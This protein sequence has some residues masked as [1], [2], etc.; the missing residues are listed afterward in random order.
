MQLIVVQGYSTLTAFGRVL[1]T[2]CIIKERVKAKLPVAYSENLDQSPGVPYQPVQFPKGLWSITEVMLTNHPLIAPVFIRTDAHQLVDQWTLDA[3]GGYGKPV[4]G[5][6][7][8]SVR[9]VQDWGYGMHFDAKFEETWGCLHLYSAEDA[10]WLGSEIMA[11]GLSM[12]QLQV[13]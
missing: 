10:H 1:K 9:Q 11:A 4:A 6:L 3:K 8:D 2:S 12:V 13:M 7:P 5:E